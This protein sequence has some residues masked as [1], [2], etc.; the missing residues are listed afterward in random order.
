MK[1]FVQCAAAAGFALLA[2]CAATDPLLNKDSWHP[3][4]A[5]AMNIAAQVVNPADLL[6]GREATGGSDGE[7]AALP[8]LRLRTNHVKPLPAS[9]IADL[10]V[11]SAP[12]AAGAP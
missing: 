12:A 6:H 7:M 2:G 9:A 10:Q 3:T 5:N 8:I 1:R 11:Q 4:G